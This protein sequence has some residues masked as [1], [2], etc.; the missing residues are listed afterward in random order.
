MTPERSVLLAAAPNGARRTKA[1]HPRLPMSAPELAETAAEVAAAG[2]A[3]LHLHV[4]DRDGHHALDAA[5]Y[6]DAI[7]AIRAAVGTRLVVQITTEAAGVFQPDAQMAA[8]DA[9]KPEAVS[10]ALRELCPD[11]ASEK[12]FAKFLARMKRERIAPQFILYD[13]DEVVRLQDLVARGI[14]PDASPSVL[15]VLGR[16]RTDR[17]SRPDD[18][19]PFVNAAEDRLP[20]FMVCAFGANEAACGVTAALLG[21]KVRVG[22]ENNLHMPDGSLA[23]DNA[24]LVRAVAGPLA[25]LGL[26][27]M[28][29]DELREHLAG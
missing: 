19:L 7:A 13:A 23:P 21:G 4:R 26:R 15:Y 22:F 16:Y 24:A 28:T 3:M 10:L 6:R 25:A 12:T 27:P 14:V 8:V 29:A 2:A 11:A 18:V 1:D 20:D 9:V 17:L 5:L